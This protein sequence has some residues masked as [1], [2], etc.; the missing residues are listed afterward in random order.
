MSKSCLMNGSPPK[1]K[2]PGDPVMFGHGV[3][4]VRQD[5]G[6]LPPP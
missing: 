1:A 6:L 3:L 5:A 4:I 2:Q